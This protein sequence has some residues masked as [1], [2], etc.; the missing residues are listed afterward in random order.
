MYNKRFYFIST[1][2]FLLV[3]GGLVVFI[4]SKNSNNIKNLPA[5]KSYS[6]IDSQKEDAKVTET[7]SQPCDEKEEEKKIELD[8]GFDEE[9]TI[10]EHEYRDAQGTVWSDQVEIPMRV[11]FNSNDKIL[12]VY[13][14]KRIQGTYE[15]IFAYNLRIDKTNCDGTISHPEIIASRPH[16]EINPKSEI[17][18]GGYFRGIYAPNGNDENEAYYF[19]PLG[20]EQYYNY[21]NSKKKN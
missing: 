15:N 20:Y 2:I 13:F 1:L 4:L 17:I 3:F 18:G 12:N 11:V 14:G 6:N 19:T 10:M 5:S 7:K 9:F 21:K 16:F 8:N